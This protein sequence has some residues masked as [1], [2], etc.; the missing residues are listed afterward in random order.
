MTSPLLPSAVFNPSGMPKTK[1]DAGVTLK[2]RLRMTRPVSNC[3]SRRCHR[4]CRSFAGA[5]SENCQ[6]NSSLSV[7]ISENN[8][9]KFSHGGDQ[10]IQSHPLR[11]QWIQDWSRGLVPSLLFQFRKEQCGTSRGEV[12]WRR[13][14]F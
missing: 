6:E 8:S 1:G 12:L 13:S 9:T 5:D 11:R 4:H 10:A 2:P 14:N 7:R 3:V